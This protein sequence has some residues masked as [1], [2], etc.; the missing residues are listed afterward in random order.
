MSVK[1]QIKEIL[2]KNGKIDN[3]YCIDTRLTTRLGAVI[4]V[5]KEE[6]LEFDEEKS[7]YIPNTKNWRYYIKNKTTLF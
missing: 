4:N 5:L 2:Q 6:G 7:G 1:S 3:Y